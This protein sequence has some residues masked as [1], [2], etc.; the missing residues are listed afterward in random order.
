VLSRVPCNQ[1]L[2]HNSSPSKENTQSDLVSYCPYNLGHPF[3]VP[4]LVTRSQLPQPGHSKLP[5]DV[6]GE[7]LLA[8]RNAQATAGPRQLPAQSSVSSSTGLTNVVYKETLDG[9]YDEW[10]SLNIPLFYF[11]RVSLDVFGGV[12]L[13]I[14]RKLT[15]MVKH[16]AP[17]HSNQLCQATVK[18]SSNIELI[19]YNT[20]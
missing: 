12:A 14:S 9:P 18:L 8:P 5:N 13:I 10:H 1:I 7:P 17:I 20:R 11:N 2:W 4:D 16:W 3:W 19:S 15:F 6:L